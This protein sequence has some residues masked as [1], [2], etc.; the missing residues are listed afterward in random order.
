M[1][2]NIIYIYILVEYNKY[3]LKCLKCIVIYTSYNHTKK[4]Q[5]ISVL[6]SYIKQRFK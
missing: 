5:W 4:K 3:C 2:C 6:K 1:F